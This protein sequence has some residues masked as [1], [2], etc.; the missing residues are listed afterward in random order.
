MSLNVGVKKMAGERDLERLLSALEP[1]LLDRTLVICTE[2][3]RALSTLPYRRVFA[4]VLEAEGLT[5]VMDREEADQHALSYEGHY[6]CLSLGVHSSLDALGLTAALSSA[7]AK[8]GISANMFAGYY[9]DHILVGA[10]DAE[11]ALTCLCD[12]KVKGS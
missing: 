10:Q 12:L 1:R 7:L 6:R 4:T 5:V 11:R 2:P 9:H 3:H 8:E